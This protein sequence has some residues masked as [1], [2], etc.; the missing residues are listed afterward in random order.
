MQCATNQ[1]QYNQQLQQ[2][3]SQ[4]QQY[5]YQLQQYQYQQQQQS[6]YG[7]YG[8]PAYAGP[9]VP[10]GPGGAPP[11]GG[12]GYGM[13]QQPPQQPPQPCFNT[14]N[15]QQCSYSPQQPA[16]G[17]CS[18]GTWKPTSSG[19]G[20]I[21]GWQCVPGGTGQS[22]DPNGLAASISCEPKVADPGMTLAIAFGCQ[23]A[24]GSAGSGFETGNKT[25][26]TATTTVKTPPSGTNT[27]TYTLTCTKDGKG[28]GAQCS[29][30]VS[31]PFLVFVASPAK[32]RSGE[33][34]VLGWIT[35]GMQSCV[36]S[37]SDFPEFTA[38]NAQ[39][40]NTSGAVSTPALTNTGHFHLHCVSYG[41]ASADED[42]VI[43]II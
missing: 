16:A 29:V 37:S 28:V 18:S 19:N 11:V 20:C 5:N 12:S 42:L 3:N 10:I 4:I 33:K 15:P 35:S 31:K 40:R 8:G 34:A 25:S 38:A 36:V 6:Y 22:G 17:S 32:V 13:Q 41:G 30:Q 23:N 24:T 2:Y 43:E 21:S 7:G 26:G 14:Q 27:A 1:D 9:Y 39:Y